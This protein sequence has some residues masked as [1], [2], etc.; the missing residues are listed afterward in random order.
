MG[1]VSL[2]PA[3]L[4]MALAAIVVTIIKPVESSLSFASGGLVLLALIGWVLEARAVAGPPPMVEPEHEEEEEA[5]G[6]SYWPVVL[7]L[8]IVGIAAGLIYNW[9]Y[10][11]LIVAVPVAI[12]SGSAWG[13]VLREEM[14]PAP[15]EG[16]YLG[17]PLRTAGGRMLMPVPGNMLA[18]QA[19]GGAAIAIEH[20]ETKQVSRRSLLLVTFW[21]G[22]LSGLLALAAMMV[23]MLYPRG[24]SGFGGIVS[25][26]TV[27]QFPPGTKK[28]IIEGKFWLVNLTAEQGGPGFL[29]LWQKCPH[30]GCTVPWKENF[31]FLD[32]ATGATKRG[33][34]R[35]PCHG[36]TYTDAGVRVYGPAPRPMD[37]ME[38]TIDPNS[39]RISVNTA[40]ITKG[41]PDNSKFAV[42][43]P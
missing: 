28:Q 24:V 33:W 13:R 41:T 22:L 26:G 18:A 4:G 29:A 7:A 17:P 21:A 31:S 20:V 5:P 36:S 6:P 1:R 19:A 30:L 42:K 25:P 23:D 15:S 35:C 16:P 14:I 34:F 32:P 27:D 3:V 43:A 11:S 38:L 12:A 9:P 10:G 39:K 37:H 40:K 8:G 2:W